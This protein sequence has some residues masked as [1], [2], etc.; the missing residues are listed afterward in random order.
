[1]RGA[2]DQGCRGGCAKEDVATFVI[3]GGHRPGLLQLVDRPLDGVALLVPLFVEA[4]G[5]STA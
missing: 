1:M 5:P 3:A 4:G 2:I